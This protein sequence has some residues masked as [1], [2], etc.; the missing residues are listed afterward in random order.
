MMATSNFHNRYLELLEQAGSEAEAARKLQKEVRKASPELAAEIIAKIEE[1]KFEV[2]SY[3]R[4][5][6]FCWANHPELPEADPWPAARFPKAV[7]FA[8]FLCAMSF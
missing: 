1:T 7:L 4:G 6:F 3:G 5:S 2:R 8:A